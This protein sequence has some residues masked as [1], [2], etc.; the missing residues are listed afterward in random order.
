MSIGHAGEQT[1]AVEGGKAT[2][3]GNVQTRAPV[4]AVAEAQAML[5]RGRPD[6]HAFGLLLQAHP[7]D[8]DALLAMLTQTVGSGFVRQMIAAVD[9]KPAAAGPSG[10]SHLRVT[11]DGLN[12]RSS[13]DETATD[14]IVGGVYR[15]VHLEG[16]GREGAWIRINYKGQPAFVH[17]GYVEAI[18]TPAPAA[19]PERAVEAAKEQAKAPVQAHDQPDAAKHVDA[20]KAAPPAPTPAAS[21]SAAPTPV[22]PAPEPARVEAKHEAKAEAKVEAKPVAPV[23]KDPAVALATASAGAVRAESELII[24]Q[25]DAGTMTLAQGIDQLAT[26]DRAMNGGMMSPTG[27]QLVATLPATIEQHRLAKIAKTHAAGD[28]QP[29]TA[30]KPPTPATTTTPVAA[31][32]APAATATA[33]DA[34]WTPPAGSRLSD[35]QLLALAAKI[36]DPHLQALLEHIG[37]IMEESKL[38]KKQT[39][40]GNYM[41]YT[42]AEHRDSLVRG[43]DVV[44]GEL[45]KLDAKDPNV[46]P[47]KVA[48]Y[49]E[50]ERLAPYHFQKN[51]RAIET[52]DKAKDKGGKRQW[53]TCNLTSLAMCLEVVG[54]NSRKF[55]A[56]HEGLL[57]QVA[58]LFEGD[59]NE[60]KDDQGDAY[61]GAVLTAKGK[62]TS[63]DKVRGFR[64]P[65][66][67]ELAAIVYSTI[68]NGHPH[69]EKGLIAGANDAANQKGTIKFLKGLATFM[70]ATPTAVNVS[71]DADPKKNAAITQKL[72]SYGS[73]H[74][75]ITTDGVEK[76]NTERNLAENAET[77]QQEAKTDKE[78]KK[79]GKEHDKAQGY[80]DKLDK[81]QHKWLDDAEIEKSL[82]IKAYK[83]A[84]TAQLGKH[85][86]AGHGVIA[87]LSGHYVRL[88][89]ITDTGVCVQDPGQWNRT[90]MRITW[91]EARAMGYFWVNLVISS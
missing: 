51:I 5:A 71:F 41:E 15:G 55:P 26:F 53:T 36:H 48:V 83:D 29:A 6:P 35:P 9:A 1:A 56:E 70:G 22:A 79:Y 54:I 63:L 43:I 31:K 89:E 14:N 23:A 30:A 8:R 28:A 50:I 81:T 73:D 91:A 67:L 60:G 10:P 52:W 44:R 13:P 12:V 19:E 72:E 61:Q 62:G 17:G 7:G 18:P 11:A 37:G 20:A 45:E 16:L 47:F 49:H 88:Y 74:R 69:T 27:A 58:K 24:Q 85:L 33:A 40:V 32:A 3:D 59:I 87:G 68:A 65:D 21:A 75:G 2:K 38:A 39:D 90:E 66:F 64:L 25:V 86:D 46:A 82:P 76:M 84:I 80:Y 42:N 34:A 77:K 78:R 4:A 57:E